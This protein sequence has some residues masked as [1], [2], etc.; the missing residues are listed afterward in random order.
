ML[1][2]DVYQDFSTVCIGVSVCVAMD[3]VLVSKVFLVQVL[4]GPASCFVASEQA[5]AGGS[6]WSPSGGMRCM[7]SE[8]TP[9]V[10]VSDSLSLSRSLSRSVYGPYFK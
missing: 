5:V 6:Y 1:G 3:D 2:K 10:P 8:S 9:S 4:H 7:K